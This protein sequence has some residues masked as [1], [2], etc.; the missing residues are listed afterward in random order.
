LALRFRGFWPW[1]LGQNIMDTGMCGRE[2]SIPWW[3][4]DKET[5]RGQDKTPEVNIPKSLP[6]QYQSLAGDLGFNLRNLRGTVHI[7]TRKHL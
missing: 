1:F 6:A 5:G 3:T 4:G 7:Q 2:T